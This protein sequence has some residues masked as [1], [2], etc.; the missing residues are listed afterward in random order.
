MIGCFS[1]HIT[2]SF[3]ELI[4]SSFSNPR[5]SLYMKDNELI[6][7]Q[8]HRTQSHRPLR[9]S[10]WPRWIILHNPNLRNNARPYR[11]NRR[12]SSSS[13]SLHIPHR[14]GFSRGRPVPHF[15]GPSNNCILLHLHHSSRL[16]LYLG[17]RPRPRSPFSHN[18]R[19]RPS[20]PQ[21]PCQRPRPRHFRTDA[22]RI[23]QFGKYECFY[24]FC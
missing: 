10:R 17:I 6:P 24:R 5:T 22:V 19:L 4:Y 20:R 13:P 1:L 11:H 7:F 16:P 9:P 18:I 23:D 14:N 12:T 21:S 8:N 2:T 3:L 15:P